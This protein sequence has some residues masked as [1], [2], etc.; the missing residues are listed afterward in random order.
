LLTNLFSA[1]LPA[2]TSIVFTAAGA[3]LSHD[4]GHADLQQLR[5]G[6]LRGLLRLREHELLERLGFRLLGGPGV[7]G[8]PFAE[9]GEDRVQGLVDPSRGAADRNVRGLPAED[10]FQDAELRAVQRQR[11]DPVLVSAALPPHVQRMLQL[12]TDPAGLQRAGA[13]HH[14]ILRR[15]LDGGLDLR[16]E[17]IAT[18]QLARVDPRVLIVV[19]EGLAELAHEG[20][21]LR[22]VRNEDL[23]HA[24]PEMPEIRLCACDA[25]LRER[26]SQ[27]RYGFAGTD[28][29][30]VTGGRSDGGGRPSLFA[31]N[32]KKKALTPPVSARGFCS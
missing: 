18:A 13:D 17:R 10:H 21:V 16:P 7:G 15:A 24:W 14:R 12:L 26:E 2:W 6:R 4:G 9:C 28:G 3:V 22:A 1:Q 29:A 30:G 31:A 32:E 5:G 25:M 23:A 8:K 27:S 20:V 19:R 11:D